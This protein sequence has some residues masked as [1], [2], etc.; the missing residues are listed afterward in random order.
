MRTAR[1]RHS[2]KPSS[3]TVCALSPPLRR[4]MPT[5]RVQSLHRIS[6]TQ[7]A[8][9]RHHGLF[10]FL[11]AA[12]H[13]RQLHGDW[14]LGT[15]TDAP[16]RHG[17]AFLPHLPESIF[18]ICVSGLA[19]GYG[20]FLDRINL[21]IG[22]VRNGSMLSKKSQIALGLFFRRTTKWRMVARRCALRPVTGVGGEFIAR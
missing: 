9:R 22:Q 21:L 19:V 14:A 3:L 5:S 11:C 8:H 7:S 4:D 1:G 17:V 15:I 18:E 10:W 16:D 12:A 6:C 2:R 13:S 20:V